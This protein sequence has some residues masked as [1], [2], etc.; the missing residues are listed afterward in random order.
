[1]APCFVG[2]IYRL[3]SV[4]SE[5]FTNRT[6]SDL[7]DVAN[8]RTFD[9]DISPAST[10]HPTITSGVRS[11]AAN[12]SGS[13]LLDVVVVRQIVV[14]HVKGMGFLLLDGRSWV[15]DCMLIRRS[16]K[17]LAENLDGTWP[18]SKRNLALRKTALESTLP[19]H[20]DGANMK[21]SGR[22]DLN[23]QPP[24]PEPVSS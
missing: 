7:W 5:R 2:S 24:G 15:W 23:H 12:G 16:A 6:V 22:V 3:L 13:E 8:W 18:I 10:P 20:K 4:S 14:H 21:L 11:K 9:P 17:M 19:R 1:M